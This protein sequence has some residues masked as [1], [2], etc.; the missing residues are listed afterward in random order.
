MG[1]DYSVLTLKKPEPRKRIKGRKDRRESQVKQQVR[2]LCVARDGDCRMAG[3]SWHVCGGA[4]EWAHLG[5]KKR[6]RTRGMKPEIRHTTDGSLMLC[7]TA[8]QDNDQGRMHI[9]LLSR[10]G[11]DRNLGFAM[12]TGHV[13]IEPFQ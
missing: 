3:I 4:S 2:A 7:T 13:Y 10:D 5:D 11:A 9:V 12:A 6:A 8:H 1:I